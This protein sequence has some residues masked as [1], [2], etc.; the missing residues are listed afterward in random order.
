MK[1][2]RHISC[3]IHN[4]R[5]HMAEFFI[6]KLCFSPEDAIEVNVPYNKM[7]PVRGC[8]VEIP[9]VRGCLWTVKISLRSLEPYVVGA[10]LDV[11]M[12]QKLYK[13]VLTH[14]VDISASTIRVWLKEKAP[15]RCVEY[16]KF[17]VA[18]EKE[19]NHK[20]LIDYYTKRRK[21]FVSFLA[22]AV[23]HE[24]AIEVALNL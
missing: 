4:T 5:I 9:T 18:I 19:V 15:K 13:Y 14:H 10:M 2:K 20:V 1:Q 11:S 23:K 16:A 3:G 7:F 17:C 6:D 24:S 12:V 22:R 8:F 21:E